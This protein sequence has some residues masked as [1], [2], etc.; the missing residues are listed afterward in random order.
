[1]NN[2]I[3]FTLSGYGAT[4]TKPYFNSYQATYNHIHKVAILGLL[5]AVIG[6]D[7]T[8]LLFNDEKYTLPKFYEELN[9]IKVAIVPSEPLFFKN[10]PTITETTGFFND[11]ET[12]VAEI[13]E[14]I[15]P[16][17]DIY[18]LNDG[19]CKHFEKIKE[20][21]LKGYSFY[22]LY[23]GKN[24]HFANISNVSIE[25]GEIKKLND[26]NK[27]DSLFPMDG[28]ELL[29]SDDDDDDDEC[30]IEYEYMVREFMP[31]GFSLLNNQYEE[32]MM[33]CTNKPISSNEDVNILKVAGNLVWFI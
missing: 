8:K 18:L 33:C 23:L 32:K 4:F 11:K 29:D 3:K 13:E 28:I 19:D 5:G 20:M 15:N 31:I 27:I 9:S 10:K 21:L 12:F 6:L 24:H 2:I 1:M 14:L 16:S 26:F 30:D 22:D 7:K 25:S 17:W